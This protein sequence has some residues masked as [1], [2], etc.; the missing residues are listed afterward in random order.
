VTEDGKNP[1]IS[2]DDNLYHV[3]KMVEEPTQEELSSAIGALR[4]AL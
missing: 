1:M 4:G 3:G 2:R